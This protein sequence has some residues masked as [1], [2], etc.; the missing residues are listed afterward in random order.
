[1]SIL[2]LCAVTFVGAVSFADE[3]EAGKPAYAEKKDFCIVCH[4]GLKGGLKRPVIEWRMSVHDGSAGRCNVCHRGDPGVNDKKLAKTK[5]SGFT[6]KP[7][8][9]LIADFC[10][11]D[12]CHAAAAGQFRLGPHY[13]SVLRN[14][15]P[16]C[17]SCHGAHNIQRST[18]GIISEKTCSSCH[19][20]DFSRNTVL[21]IRE[22]NR[23]IEDMGRDIKYIGSK[24]GDTLDLQNR[25]D[26]ARTRF[27]RFVHV[28]PKEEMESTRKLLGVEVSSLEADV[29]TKV[30]LI[31]RIDLLYIV[32]VVFQ[33]IFIGGISIY[34]LVMYSKRRKYGRD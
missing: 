1:M 34:T 18:A 31:G 20:A 21:F 15:H 3:R 29:K 25:L 24:H 16:N 23:A 27:Y 17:A 7:D 13:P 19:T 22:T 5:Q 12:G 28:S 33:L 11:R 9:I 30:S 26:T 2:I 10:G 8:K 14:N 6:G 32:M 4:E